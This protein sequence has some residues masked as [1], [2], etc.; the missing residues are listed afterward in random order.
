MNANISGEKPGKGNSSMILA[1]GVG[2]QRGMDNLLNGEIK[3]WFKT[4]TWWV[5]ILIWASAINLV[6]LMVSL[7]AGDA[8]GFES[9]MIFNIFMGLAGPIGTCI[10]MQMA[11]VGETRSGTAA[12]IL[13]KPVSRTAFIISKLIGNSLGLA[14]TMVLAQGLIAY[15]ITAF[16]LGEYLPIAG[17][18]AGL[19]VQLV[20][21][22]FYLTITLM[23]GAIF[24]HPA[25]VIG[26]PLAFLF[27]QQY[28][29]GY[30][31]ALAKVLP[32]TLAIPLNDAPSIAWALMTGAPVPSFSPV[33][34]TLAFS[35]LFVAIA[36]IVFQRQEL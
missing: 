34:F 6:Y 23:C 27:A 13:S 3:H 18:L 20:N 14:V 25:P 10:V 33:Y 4:R 11:V 21:I 31:P 16:V 26:L 29:I 28:I 24:D 22:M 17:F 15:L 30:F 12:W 2:W 9:I 7:G 19:A 1:T 35:L 32:W 36:L 8:P 5:Q